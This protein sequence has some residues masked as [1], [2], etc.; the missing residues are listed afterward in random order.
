VSEA[1]CQALTKSDCFG[2]AATPRVSR[3][4]ATD[5]L[6]GLSTV[7]SPHE[8]EPAYAVSCRLQPTATT[9]NPDEN[10]S[11]RGVLRGRPS[12]HVP[13]TKLNRTPSNPSAR[14]NGDAPV[15][16]T[17]PARRQLFGLLTLCHEVACR[18]KPRPAAN[19]QIFDRPSQSLHVRDA[20]EVSETEAVVKVVVRRG[21][22]RWDA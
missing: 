9:A 21:V 17:D 8:P 5:W 2:A 18:R 22:M 10:R 1:S 14:D 11:A 7:D 13:A 16:Q 6:T 12:R 19:C 4:R 3:S 20:D 15:A